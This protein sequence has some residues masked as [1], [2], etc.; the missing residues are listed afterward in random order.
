MQVCVA[1]LLS[2]KTQRV[3][4]ATHSFRET[5]SRIQTAKKMTINITVSLLKHSQKFSERTSY[6]EV[7]QDGRVTRPPYS[8]KNGA[9]YTGQWLN[10]MRD[11]YGIQI[12][13]DGSRYEGQWR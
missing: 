3:R 13:P 10:E 12:W 8:F 9:T 6:V 1:H 7:D 11:G 5:Y 4:Y 2:T